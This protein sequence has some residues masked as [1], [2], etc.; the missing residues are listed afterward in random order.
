MCKTD[1]DTLPGGVCQ[2]L[3][4]HWKPLLHKDIVDFSL[5]GSS[6]SQ[7][8]SHHTKLAGVW[9]STTEILQH[10]VPSFSSKKHC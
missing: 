3:L 2:D 7:V 8:L 9:S 10:C 6:T 5:P 4:D 1:K